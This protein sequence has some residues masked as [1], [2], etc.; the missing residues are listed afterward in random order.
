MYLVV[1][2]MSY[3]PSVFE[4]KSIEEA[5]VIYNN[6]FKDMYVDEDNYDWENDEDKLY[7]AKV[8]KEAGTSSGDVDWYVN[9]R[10]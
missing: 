3:Y 9:G 6:I 2:K 7:I 4:C 1:N 5:E 10:R 8:V